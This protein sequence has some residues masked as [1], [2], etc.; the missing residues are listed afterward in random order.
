MNSDDIR[1][2]GKKFIPYNTGNPPM[3]LPEYGR[4]I[5]NM[6]DHCVM[7][8]DREERTACAYAIIEVMKTLFPKAVADKNDVSKFW[9]HLNIMARY[10]LDIDFPCEV[11]GPESRNV[12]PAKVPYT[13]SKL[14]MRTYGHNIESMIHAVADMEPGMERDTLIDDI[15]NQMKKLLFAQNPESADNVRII[16][17]LARISNGKIELDP[18]N[19]YMPEYSEFDTPQKKSKKKKLNLNL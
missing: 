15:V 13:Q 1:I 12:K 16:R 10:E 8:P 6:V 7:I 9:D 19:Y 14:K 18:Y 17:D 4:T 2:E 5:Q 11:A 3:P